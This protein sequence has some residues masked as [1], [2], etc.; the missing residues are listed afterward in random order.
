MGFEEAFFITSWSIYNR[1]ASVLVQYGLIYLPLLIIWYQGYFKYLDDD[2]FNNIAVLSE[3]NIRYKII[4]FT[5]LYQIA[6]IPALDVSQIQAN[7]VN[8]STNNNANNIYSDRIITNLQSLNTSVAND[9]HEIKIPFIWAALET[10]IAVFKS[11]LF[12]VIP[13]SAKELRQAIIN[14]QKT[15]QIKSPELAN[16]YSG[17]YK[18]CF[19]KANAKFNTM[20]EKGKISKDNWFWN[21][22]KPD[23]DKEEY[24]WPGGSFYLD[25]QTGKGFYLQCTANDTTCQNGDTWN[26]YGFSVSYQYTPV[27]ST[28]TQTAY[29]YC[30]E[31]WNT[32][33]RPL[34]IEEFE[35]RDG[36]DHRYPITFG[37]KHQNEILR[38]KLIVSEFNPNALGLNGADANSIGSSPFS[39]DFWIN[40]VQYVITTVIGGLAKF[41]TGFVN[42][43][44]VTALPLFQSM[45][46]FFLVALLPFAII[47]SAFRIDILI[48]LLMFYFTL[49]MLDVIWALVDFLDKVLKDVIYGISDDSDATLQQA[50]A[51]ILSNVSLIGVTLDIMI[52]IAYIVVTT[53]WFNLMKSIGS[54]MMDMASSGMSGLSSS[55]GGAMKEVTKKIPTPK[56]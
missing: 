54:D 42:M 44:I 10:G 48:G 18:S 7:A 2:S 17:F 52:S 37:E 9:A 30:A 53:F 12:G 15:S 32:H 34:L 21:I 47:L 51:T 50:A 28:Q 36:I 39:A 5:V 4:I 24:D 6:F 38:N 33:V 41:I 13:S 49:S 27:G 11:S 3:K 40:L 8:D 56:L 1:F 16:L 14:T 25:Q 20:I 43:F 22:F 55:T 31:V 19:S 45:L 29:K 26:P 23:I 35:I 46:M